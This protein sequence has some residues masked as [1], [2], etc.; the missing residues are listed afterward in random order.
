MTWFAPVVLVSVRF[1]AEAVGLSR[2]VVGVQAKVVPA[3]GAF[4]PSAVVVPEQNCRA[5]PATATAVGFTVMTT[6]LVLKQPWALVT[7]RV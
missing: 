3:T 2:P 6:L 5:G 7:V 1:G 4:V